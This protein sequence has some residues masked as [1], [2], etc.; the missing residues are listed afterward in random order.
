M[1]HPAGSHTTCKFFETI[2]SDQATTLRGLMERQHVLLSQAAHEL[3]RA[4]TVAIT[5]GKGGVGKS[6]IAL[7]LAIALARQGA[8][9]CL[10][11]ANLGLGNID[12]LYGAE[13]DGYWNLSHVITGAR[14]LDEVVLEGPAGVRLIPAASGL[15]DLADAPASARQEILRQFEEL[16]QKHDFLLIDTA[17]GSHRS[18]LDFVALADTVL[19]V[20]TPEPTSI[21]DAY[22]TIKALAGSN[23]LRLD[24]LVNQAE[25]PQAE[26]IAA[27]F[28]QTARQFLHVELG[29]AGSIPHDREVPLAVL[30]RR[31]FQL[32]KP[33]CP[34][35]RAIAQLAHRLGNPSSD[36]R[37]RG[38][39]LRQRLSRMAD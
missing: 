31:P 12:L 20:T 35:A 32:E 1:T 14:A 18:V 23:P 26:A 37:P 36:R 24:V 13:R 5:S 34:A 22:A 21:T 28:Q 39:R 3:P 30:Q 27:Q 17:S 15:C 38:P 8:S 10:L 33:Q 2:M 11:D 19:V 7:N 16:E 29:W 4:Q 9:V 6:N 25:T